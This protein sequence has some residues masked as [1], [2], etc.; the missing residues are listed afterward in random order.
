MQ[1]AQK[2]AGYSLGEADLLRKAMGKKK[3]EIMEEQRAKFADGAV[4]NGYTKKVASEIFDYIEPFA[5]YGFNKSH[6]VAYA[7]LAYQTAWLKVHYPRHFMAAVLSS[8]MD[9]TDSVVKFIN[10]AAAMGIALL[11]PDINESNYSFT[12]VAQNIRFGL[13]AVKGVGES[14]IESILA[15]RREVGRFESLMHFCEHVDM[16]SCN[17]KVVEALVK[18]GS[19]DSIGGTRKAIFD[20]IE[21]DMDA[22]AKARDERERGQASLFGGGP[23]NSITTTVSS[24]GVGSREAID[25]EWSDDEKLQYEKETLGFYISGHPLNKFAEEIGQFADANTETIAAKVDAEVNIGGIVGQLKKNKIK[26][27]PNEGKLMAKF[28]L[29]D[30]FGS[31]EVV[32]FADLYARVASWLENGVAVFMSA[33]VKDTGG[34]PA[35]RSASLASAEAQARYFEDE[36]G[37]HPEAGAELPV[38]SDSAVV[39]TRDLA[40]AASQ[41]RASGVTPELNCL[42]IMRLD[43]IRDA[44][45]KEIRVR[46]PY[47]KANEAS[48]VRLREIIESH[49]GEVPV[50]VS[51]TNVPDE[52]GAVANGGGEVVIRLN[53]HFKVHP[54]PGVSSA[55]EGLDAKVLYSF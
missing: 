11:P 6:S 33:R 38:E 48:I 49:P 19:F 44:K 12:V 43:G 15:A 25:E 3:K 5:R 26:K 42:E 9:K 17:K 4:A 36:Y 14:A 24:G 29:D 34:V 40:E 1:I 16:R 10:E 8:E 32:V 7:L 55:L 21:R 54:G 18:S 46:L 52:L 28:V 30:Q 47:E 27:G 22:A 50:T 35:G 41:A 13:G 23:V 2:V 45:V 51:L 20:E 39:E 37:G 53:T 31:V